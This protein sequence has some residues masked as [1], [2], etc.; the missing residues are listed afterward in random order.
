VSYTWDFGDGSP[1]ATG[2]TTSH[3]YAAPGTYT[4][5]L[6]IVDS[7]GETATATATVPVT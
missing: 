2:V 5:V 6:T 3:P 1:A 7:E 4:V